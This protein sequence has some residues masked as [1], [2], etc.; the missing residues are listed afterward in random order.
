M[1][2]LKHLFQSQDSKYFLKTA[3]KIGMVPLL[4]SVLITYSLWIYMEM[5]Y[6][7][8]L[9]NGFG[10]GADM[11]E[12]FWDHLMMSQMDFIPWLG[13]FYVGVFFV[14]LFLAHL[15]LRPF[16]KVQKMCNDVLNGEAPELS[17]DPMTAR[18]LV[19]RSAV[20]FMEYIA[21]QETDTET[22]FEIPKDLEKI[23]K[24]RADG[25]FYLQYVSFMF[26]LSA[27]TG[28]AVYM[29]V[30]HLHESIV[31]TAMTLLK[32]NKSIGTFLTS[33]QESI[34]AIAW[35]CT[36]FSTLLYALLAK[37]IISEVEGVSYG[38]LRDI[39][40]IVSGDHIK[41]LRPRFNDPGKDA[42]LA[43]NQLMN[44]LFPQSESKPTNVVELHPHVQREVPPAFVEEFHSKD[45][46]RLYRVVTPDG[47]VVEGLSYQD[48]IKVLKEVG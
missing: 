17:T 24:P 26:I 6:S 28:L 4:S 5:N 1:G 35:V 38:Y 45:G 8:F 23:R 48:T 33:Q 30:M 15:V 22:D 37:G 9:A 20:L 13:A 11:K 19:I 2:P 12:A 16:S 43:I 41:R 40:D 36:G 29:A 21:S 10:S 27:I 25:V 7:F 32:S 39:R 3:F 31:E 34:E 46:T 18:K 42:A 47:Q 44:N 14:G